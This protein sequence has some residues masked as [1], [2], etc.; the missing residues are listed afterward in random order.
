M[1]G[2]NLKE[3]AAAQAKLTDLLKAQ[4]GAWNENRQA[5]EQARAQVE[6]HKE[7]VLLEAKTLD[8]FKAALSAIEGPLAQ[9]R[10]SLQD[11]E[12]ALADNDKA[13]K[14][15][16]GSLGTLGGIASSAFGSLSASIQGFVRSGLEGTAE[17]EQLNMAMQQLSQEIAAVFLPVVEQAVNILREAT[18]WFR[19]L[20]GEQ[21][22]M[23]AKWALWA[24]GI[25]MGVSV[26][27]KFITV[28]TAVVGAMRAMTTAQLVLNAA[29]GQWLKLLIG[30][31]A[32]AGAVY[33]AK[34]IFAEVD[35]FQAAGQSASKAGGGHRT[36]TRSGASYEQAQDAFKRIQ[37]AAIKSDSAYFNRDKAA[38]DTAENTGGMKSIL[39]NIETFL[40]RANPGARR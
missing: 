17:G 28:A 39:G 38:R 14:S 9:Q 31:A 11:G 1:A 29:T 30:G 22:D 26:L 15:L 13:I 36:V 6:K 10:K 21:Q 7:A 8:Q 19:N 37:L 35:K 33:A 40:R 25:S 24:A 23:I 5:I 4:Q 12:K 20:S 34:K 3:L 18:A 27:G 32:A 16:T 2:E